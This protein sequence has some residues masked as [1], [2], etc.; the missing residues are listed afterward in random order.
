MALSM[1][2]GRSPCWKTPITPPL[3][4]SGPIDSSRAIL[5]NSSSPVRSSRR[6]TETAFSSV[7]TRIWLTWM[8]P[9]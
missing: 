3:A 2:A 4:A 9:C 6:T 8:R 7:S 1:S 5:R